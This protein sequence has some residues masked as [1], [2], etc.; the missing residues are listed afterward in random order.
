MDKEEFSI[1]FFRG[2]KSKE[3]KMTRS[4]AKRFV[5]AFAKALSEGLSED[6]QLTI[7]NFGTFLVK[8][9]GARIILNPQGDGRKFFMPPTD[10]VKWIPSGKIRVRAET[11]SISDDKWQKLVGHGSF[12]EIEEEVKKNKVD[13]KKDCD[14]VNIKVISNEEFFIDEFSPIS[15]FVRKIFDYSNKIGAKKIELRP[16]KSFSYIIYQTD[17]GRE[18]KKIIKDSHSVI[19]AKIKRMK[20]KSFDFSSQLS[21]FG[22]ILILDIK[23]E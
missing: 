5:L 1:E 15:K 18:K 6:R 2:M 7:S 12:E 10:I 9:V 21:P 4:E 22:E 20:D 23:P 11:A 13:E 3:V 8:K 16:E 19:I 14:S 17:N